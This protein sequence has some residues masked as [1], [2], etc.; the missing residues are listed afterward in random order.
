LKNVTILTTKAEQVR[1][2]N[3]IFSRILGN[4]HAK[5]MG[6][7][8]A[9]RKLLKMRGLYPWQ[10]IQW[11]LMEDKKRNNVNHYDVIDGNNV[12]PYYGWIGMVVRFGIDF[13][14]L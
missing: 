11:V 4:I 6:G 9:K 12:N 3:E 10:K 7:G 13:Y 8:Y 2:R 5:N 14:R 1:T